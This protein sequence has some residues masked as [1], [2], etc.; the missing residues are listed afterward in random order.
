MPGHKPA[1]QRDYPKDL[2]DNRNKNYHN[3]R[4][5]ITAKLAQVESE[6]ESD[7]MDLEEAEHQQ[8]TRLLCSVMDTT[9][10]LLLNWMTCS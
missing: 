3:N 2:K 1:H 7:D 10:V 4:G 9:S 6:S 5:V 8:Q